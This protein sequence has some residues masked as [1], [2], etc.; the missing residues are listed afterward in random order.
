MTGGMAL[1]RL[2]LAEPR[3]ARRL[4]LIAALRTD[5]QVILLTPTEDPLRVV[6]REHPEVVVLGCHPSQ[7]L[8]AVR[9]CRA[10]K[11][12]H[13]P[14]LV[15]VLNGPGVTLD[16]D[17]VLSHYL[18]DGYLRGPTTADGVATWVAALSAG[19]RPITLSGAGTPLWKRLLI[20]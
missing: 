19:E 6:R 20:R 18:A 9:T 15:G 10:L 3:N 5:H 12:E 13:D 16:P 1:P 17:E 7:P 8:A 2:L 4:E 14:P 11:T